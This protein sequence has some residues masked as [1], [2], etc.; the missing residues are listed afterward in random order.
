MALSTLDFSWEE[1]ELSEQ[2]S[3]YLA[4]PTTTVCAQ[5]CMISEKDP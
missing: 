2:E 4:L 5:G 1:K 3:S